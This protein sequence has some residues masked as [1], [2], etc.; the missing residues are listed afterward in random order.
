MFLAWNGISIRVNCPVVTLDSDVLGIGVRGA[1]YIQAAILILL[2]LFEI[3][4]EDVFFS[5]LSIQVTSAAL[6]GAAYFDRTIDVPHTLGA[7]QFSVLFSACR[8]T[9]YDLPLRFLLSKSAT[10]LVSQI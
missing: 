7:S 6:I 8:I 1:L 5:T 9:Y 4:P 2:T 10:K 3:R